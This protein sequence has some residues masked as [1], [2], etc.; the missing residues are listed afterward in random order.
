MN[1]DTYLQF[2]ADAQRRLPAGVS[3][4]AV[5]FGTMKDWPSGHVLVATQQAGD[6]AMLLEMDAANV[7]DPRTYRI[8]V[9]NTAGIADAR[10]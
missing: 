3:I 1:R 4:E 5:P 10:Q 2:L 7:N 6:T 8:V 9:T